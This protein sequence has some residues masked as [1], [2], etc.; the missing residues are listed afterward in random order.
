MGCGFTAQL[1]AMRISEEVDALEVMAIPSLPFLVTTRMIGGL[2]AI[3]PIYVVALMTSYVATR[4]V[5]VHVLRPVLGY[6][7]P[8]LFQF[9]PA[10][11]VL[12]SFGKVLVFA[13]S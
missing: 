13:V 10:A 8:L 4:F 6:L 12:W 7:R 2:I 3:I 9:L 5:V 11:D 1:G